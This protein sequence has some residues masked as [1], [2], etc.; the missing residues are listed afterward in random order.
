MMAAVRA[1]WLG[2]LQLLKVT[3]AA[4]QAAFQ[5]FQVR[6]AAWDDAGLAT[7]T[8]LRE[9][10]RTSL[11]NAVQLHAGLY[12]QVSCQA[13]RP[14]FPKYLDSC[15]HK[16]A[17]VTTSRRPEDVYRVDYYNLSSLG[18]QFSG[19]L[20]KIGETIAAQMAAHPVRGVTLV[21]LP[22]CPAWGAGSSGELKGEHLE[23]AIQGG[24]LDVL[25]ELKKEAHELM[26]R[27][28][29]GV[30]DVKTMCSSD[31]PLRVD[32]I[33]L[34]S[35]ITDSAGKHVAH[36]TKS[37]LWRGRGIPGNLAV[38]QRGDYLD[39][40]SD[41]DIVRRGNCDVGVERRQWDSGEPFYAHVLTSLFDKV[42]LTPL[43]ACHVREW[44]LY[45][46]S[47]LRA[48]MNLNGTQGPRSAYPS[49]AYAGATW[50]NFIRS[51]A[52]TRV[53]L[54]VQTS[55][56]DH[57]AYLVAQGS[58]K[59]P[60]YTP[61]DASQRAAKPRDGAPQLDLDT[62]KLT[63]PREQELPLRQTVLDTWT[64][65][66]EGGCPDADV[67]KAFEELVRGHD[68]AWN[69][70]GVP[71]KPNSRPAE[72]PLAQLPEAQAI[73]I[74]APAGT[75][76]TLA[77]LEA[78]AGPLQQVPGSPPGRYALVATKAGLLFL[79]GLEDAVIPLEPLLEVRGRYLTG[80]AAN[81][82]MS[83]KKEWVHFKL[84]DSSMVSTSIKKPDARTPNGP[85]V[86]TSN[87][88]TPQPLSRF[89]ATLER[90]GHVRSKLR[91]HSVTRAAPR[92]TSPGWLMHSSN[93]PTN[94]N[95]L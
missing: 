63:S 85:D 24:R 62:F 36:F 35:N 19:F 56:M 76:K 41:L 50:T 13:D 6:R 10:E 87:D 88:P 30:Y 25:A 57:L 79:L 93:A 21:S 31:R 2:D 71:W 67:R 11:E 39:W 70:T 66:R 18:P 34:V 80:A 51:K 42:G 78:T 47:L 48:V 5:T 45:S 15:L 90:L 64:S 77:D 20:T 23:T 38:L 91:L 84:D 69:P 68:L 75:P 94:Q 53:A 49:L 1:K 29:T 22:N 52:G 58:Y 40:A 27:E 43:D 32:M 89:L 14:L 12:Y 8:A 83:N 81:A 26:C 61:S 16:F 44:T 82:M 60:S 86:S 54:N 9:A 28:I 92:E 7:L 55:A 65:G 74:T 46:D 72:V 17:E 3:L 59:L 4:E 73:R 95:L 33:M 37:R